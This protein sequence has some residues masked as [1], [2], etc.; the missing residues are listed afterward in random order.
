MERSI[1]KEITGANLETYFKERQYDA[2]FYPSLFPLKNVLRLDYTTLIG[3]QNGRVAADII[4]FNASAPLKSRQIV[5]KLEG[6]IPKT[7]VKR[8][9]SESDFLDYFTL[10]QLASTDEKQILDLVF[11]DI[12]FVVDS[13]AGRL[14]WLALTAINKTTVE[15]TVSNNNGLVTAVAVDFQ[16]PTNNK[17]AA[18]VA[19]GSGVTTSKPITDFKT[20]VKSARAKGRKLAYALMNPDTFDYMLD[21]TEMQNLIKAYFKLE[22]SSVVPIQS[23]DAVNAVLK[24]NQLPEI[25]IIDQSIG[26][27]NKAGV[28]TYANPFTAD[29]VTFVPSLVLGDYLNAPIAEELAKPAQVIQSKAGNILV[30]K[31]SLVDPVAEFTKGECNSFPS[32]KNIDSCWSL[33]ATAT[34]WS[35]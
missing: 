21:S 13:V 6:D 27:E 25:I 29:F 4:A 12:D 1:L 22:V 20:V 26:I 19:W 15:L 32:W 24:G 3:E 17:K 31:F 9:M 16:M 30:S 18:S 11:S 35:A 10:S 7:A 28:I 34:T 14:E 33:R 5:S 8:K 23:L 2:M